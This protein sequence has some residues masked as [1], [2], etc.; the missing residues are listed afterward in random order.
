MFRG[1]A[2]PCEVR[3]ARNDGRGLLKNA[4]EGA[5]SI[6]VKNEIASATTASRMFRGIATACKV[7]MARNDGRGQLKN[8]G[9]DTGA[10]QSIY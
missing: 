5:S 7:R 9:G 2:T 3:R 4:G 6:Q 8:A 1:I 10:I